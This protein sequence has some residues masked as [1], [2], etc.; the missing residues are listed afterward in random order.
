MM[1]EPMS[2]KNDAAA[3]V[4]R[5]DSDSGRLVSLDIA[6]SG[7]VKGRIIIHLASFSKRALG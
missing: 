4:R 1:S 7:M 6:D 3:R 5:A 2:L